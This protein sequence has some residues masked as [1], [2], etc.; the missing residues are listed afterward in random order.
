M[1]WVTCCADGTTSFRGECY[2]P[3]KQVTGVTAAAMAAIRSARANTSLDIAVVYDG[4]APEFLDFLAA[5]D[6]HCIQHRFSHAADPTFWPDPSAA[7]EL[8]PAGLPLR[9]IAQNLCGAFLRFDVPSLFSD[10]EYILYTDTDVI[11]QRDPVHVFHDVR[12]DAVIA[13]VS[14]GKASCY[15]VGPTPG[16]NDYINTG[17]LLFNVQAWLQE[18][19]ALVA[20]ARQLR[21]G[22]VVGGWDEGVINRHFGKRIQFL[23][24]TFNWR[25]WWGVFEAAPIVHYHGARVAMLQE[26][27]EWGIASPDLPK[28]VPNLWRAGGSGYGQ[29]A[30]GSRAVDMTRDIAQYYVDL[31]EKYTS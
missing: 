9:F 27:L 10:Q 13:G 30:A 11:F 28:W 17:V 2:N 6:V 5:H 16:S 8:H 25:P 3:S 23:R 22:S 26:Y 18:F 19:D 21:W 1:L 24:R 15:P 29:K 12:P 14:Y 7:T 4:D 20:T 31:Y